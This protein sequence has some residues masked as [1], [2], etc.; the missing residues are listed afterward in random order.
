MKVHED[1]IWSNL[2]P[3][4]IKKHIKP[5][6]YCGKK[7]I[8][9]ELESYSYTEFL[10]IWCICTNC[11]AYTETKI[12]DK[13]INL[14]TLSKKWTKFGRSHW[15]NS[16]TTINA[17]DIDVVINDNLKRKECFTKIR[18]GFRS[19]KQLALFTI[20]KEYYEKNE[21][22]YAKIIFEIKGGKFRKEF[23]K[24]ME[25]KGEN[26]IHESKDC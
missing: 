18:F 9:V 13:K 19:K 5:C 3:Q 11:D 12:S 20:I 17:R 2:D 24:F 26:D 23:K 10:R 1:N 4:K 16:N 15:N 25:N 7:E 21:L 6:P 22:V 14:P 8:V